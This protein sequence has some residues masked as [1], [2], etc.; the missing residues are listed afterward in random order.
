RVGT[1]AMSP[2][3][4]REYLEGVAGNGGIPCQLDDALR[5]LTSIPIDIP[6]T[7]E[8]SR[9]IRLVEGTY[10]GAALNDAL[11]NNHVTELRKDCINPAAIYAK[12]GGNWYRAF[13]RDCAPLLSRSPEH[14]L[15]KLLSEPTWRSEKST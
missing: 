8:P 6:R 12:A 3:D 7:I 14:R 5:V 2:A 13:R 1:E 4:R 15:F 9:G 11:R 10:S